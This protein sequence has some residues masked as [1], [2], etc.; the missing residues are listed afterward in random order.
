MS[1][2]AFFLSKKASVMQFSPQKTSDL[3]FLFNKKSPTVLLV[4]GVNILYY[5]GIQVGNG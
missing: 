2:E 5:F 4:S 1:M 3:N